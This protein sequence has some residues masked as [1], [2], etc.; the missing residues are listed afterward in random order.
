VYKPVRSVGG[1]KL[2]AVSATFLASGLFHEWLLPVVFYDVP[3]IHYGTTLL[4][5]LWQAVLVGIEALLVLALSNFNTITRHPQKKQNKFHP[6]ALLSSLSFYYHNILPRP[7]RTF[8]II[9]L[10]V[11]LGHWFCD[12]YV[13]SDFFTVGAIG[14]PCFRP[15]VS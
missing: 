2:L 8:I 9:V 3:S 10:G 13:R 6:M 4:F 15:I 5:F 7:L 12:A 14:L 11:P 1:N